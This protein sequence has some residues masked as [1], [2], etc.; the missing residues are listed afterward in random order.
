MTLDLHGLLS[1][2]NMESSAQRFFI[3][4]CTFLK[5]IGWCVKHEVHWR[6]YFTH[7]SN[8]LF[9]SLTSVICL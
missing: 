7:L 4:V 6:I 8:I 1:R 9:H 2:D 5:K 3:F